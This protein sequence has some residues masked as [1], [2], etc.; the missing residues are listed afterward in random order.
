MTLMLDPEPTLAAVTPEDETQSL[1]AWSQ[2]DTATEVVDYRPRSWK[3]PTVAAL[4]ATA[5]LTAGAFLAWPSATNPKVAPSTPQVVAP[6]IPA[7]P[8]VQVQSPDQ[9]FIA[10][11]KQRGQ[12]VIAPDTAIRAAH[13]VCTA[14]SQ[15]KP[16]PQI[17]A[18]L[19]ASTAG[20][21]MKMATVFLYTAQSVYCP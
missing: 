12:T 17:A 5:A 19:V 2:E 15:G 10:L 16:D 11:L 9:R 6:A 7:S 14:E 3:V 18:E 21:D 4:A 20:S 8:P 13:A 1:H